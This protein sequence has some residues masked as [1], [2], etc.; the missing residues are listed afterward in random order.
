MNSILR[1]PRR[2]SPASFV[3]SLEING[4][5]YDAEPLPNGAD[6][7]VVWSLD[8]PSLRDGPYHVT[9]H[10]DSLVSCTC[11]SYVYQMEGTSSPCKHG[12]AAIAAGLF[13]PTPPAAL[14]LGGSFPHPDDMGEDDGSSPDDRSDDRPVSLAGLPP[15]AP[16]SGEDTRWSG[17]RGIGGAGAVGTADGG[18]R[19]GWYDEMLAAWE[20]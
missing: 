18:N 16:L 6:G 4:R 17:L 20:C 3:I 12:R 8:Y 1:Q 11:P 10:P 5:H 2:Q 7:E 15:I 19:D 9:R 13:D 14:I